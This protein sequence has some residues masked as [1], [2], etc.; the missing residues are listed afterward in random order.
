LQ[1]SPVY[2]VVGTGGE[3]LRNHWAEPAP[4]WSV[5]REATQNGYTSI[6]VQGEEFLHLQFIRDDNLVSDEMYICKSPP[7]DFSQD[8][9]GGGI[10]A[11][12]AMSKLPPLVLIF[13]LF[14]VMYL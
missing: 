7:C 3:G 6:Y 14:V 13:I 9:N 1:H 10:T 2:F 5:H 4:E 12:S 11:N 8:P